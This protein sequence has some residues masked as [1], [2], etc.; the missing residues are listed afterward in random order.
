[1]VLMA[2]MQEDWVGLE[3]M[4]RTMQDGLQR[5]KYSRKPVVTAPWG[6]T[7]GGGVEVAMHSA[8]TVACGEMYSG[9]VEVGVGV[10]PAGGGCKEMLMRFL[11]DQPPGVAIDPNPYVQKVFEYIATAKIF[12]SAEEARDGRFLRVT[13][14]VEMD[15]EAVIGTAKQM[16]LGLVAGGY[17]PPRQRTARV[18]GTQGRATLE[19]ALYQFNKGGQATDY[20]VVV[21]KKVANVL[22]GGDVPYGTVRTEQ[23]ILDL[24]R[25]AFLSLCGNPQTQARIQHMLEKGKPLRN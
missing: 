11:G 13:D 23:D 8:A 18:P 10:L 15:Q 6:L 7:L 2:S 19:L 22:C 1:M 24:E 25:E 5:A 21:G 9:L 4:I 3:K 20:D 17:Q 14:R 16:A 12:M